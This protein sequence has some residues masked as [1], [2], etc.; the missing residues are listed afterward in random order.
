MRLRV[1]NPPARHLKILPTRTI[2]IFNTRKPRCIQGYIFVF[3]DGIPKMHGTLTG[4]MT[5]DEL[6]AHKGI[7]KPLVSLPGCPMKPEHFV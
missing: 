6:L 5:L 3:E 4:S 1:H 2:C 7:E